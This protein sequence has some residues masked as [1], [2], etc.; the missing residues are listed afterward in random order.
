MGEVIKS[1]KLASDEVRGILVAPSFQEKAISAASVA[2]NITLKSY[3]LKFQ[4]EEV[5]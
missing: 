3:E 2:P 5:I 1:K 4:F